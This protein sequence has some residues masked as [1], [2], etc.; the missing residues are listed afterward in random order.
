MDTK[1]HY[2]FWMMKWWIR[3]NFMEMRFNLKKIELEHEQTIKQL[4]DQL[5]EMQDT[6]KLYCLKRKIMQVHMR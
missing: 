4:E 1:Y 5:N 3:V 6:Y 2:G